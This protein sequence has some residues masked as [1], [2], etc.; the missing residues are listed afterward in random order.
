MNPAT[1]PFLRVAWQG[2]NPGDTIRVRH[3]VV[4]RVA[5]VVRIARV[6][7]GGVEPNLK[8]KPFVV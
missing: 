2:L 3:A 5:V 6:R 7:R 4:V 8:L 1:S